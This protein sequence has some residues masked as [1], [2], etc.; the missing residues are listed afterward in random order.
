[1]IDNT[2]IADGWITLVVFELVGLAALI[3]F[4]ILTRCGV[5]GRLC[6]ILKLEIPE[7]EKKECAKGL[8][9]SDFYAE[10]IKAEV[11]K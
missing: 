11:M 9:N 2:I 3:I 1:M 4:A 8:Y 10:L 5:V 6:Q 7:E